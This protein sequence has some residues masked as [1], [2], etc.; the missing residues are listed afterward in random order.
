MLLD[1]F[2]DLLKTPLF[3]RLKAVSVYMSQICAALLV[4]FLSVEFLA[5]DAS[6]DQ[7]V[8]ASRDDDSEVV[9]GQTQTDKP[10]YN[11][12]NSLFQI[13]TGR[14]IGTGRGGDKLVD[15]GSTTT[16]SFFPRDLALSTVL[17]ES[18]N[19]YLGLCVSDSARAA[20]LGTVTDIN[21][22]H[23]GGYVNRKINN[24][25][26]NK[27]RPWSLH[28]SG[29]ALDIGR[30]DI[31]AGGKKLNIPMTKASHDGRNGSHESRFYK[32]FTKCWAKYNK[33]KCGY[34]TSLDCNHN[35]LHYDHVHI[36]LP[37]C[38]R[39]PGIAST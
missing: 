27:S 37:F 34:K 19:K 6:A 7:N 15:I 2:L 18:M 33:N 9:S 24:G 14:N 29:R 28:A 11:T 25:S 12:T 23:M 17:V 30:I 39:K 20:G 1:K 8:F 31:V 3:T 21:V 35:R 16:M 10:S 5:G 13:N 4:V 32:E 36:A 22:S 38:K 26:R